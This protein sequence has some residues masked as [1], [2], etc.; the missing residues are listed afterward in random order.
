MDNSRQNTGLI[1]AV[2]VL[3]MVILFGGVLFTLSSMG[4]LSFEN[5][6]VEEEQKPNKD[7]SEDKQE[8]QTK[9]NNIVEKYLGKWYLGDGSQGTYTNINIK[10]T[11][12][13]A[14]NYA[15]DI[16]V[17]K[18]ANYSNLELYCADNSGVCYAKGDENHHYAIVMA[19][20]MVIVI[21][22][23]AVAGTTW[24]FATKE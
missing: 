24:D 11:S 12:D 17:N 18:E 5:N 20:E 1:I 8:T 19:N 7:E 14:T 3:V 10:K 13:S 23:R 21:P 4:Y 9:T 2:I 22:E 6:T 16:I 15:I